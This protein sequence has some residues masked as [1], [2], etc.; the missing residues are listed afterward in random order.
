MIPA[1][2]SPA[3]GCLPETLAQD[4]TALRAHLQGRLLPAPLSPEADLE[5]FGCHEIAG[6]PAEPEFFATASPAAVLL[7]LVPR[8]TGFGVLLTERAAHLRRHAGQVAF[9]GGR[10]E[11]GESAQQAAL[12][13][14]HEEIGLNP[15]FVA[16]LGFMPPYFSGTGYRVQPVVALVDAKAPFTAD[17][18]EVARIFEVPLRVVLDLANY[19]HSTIFWR[20]R[21]RKY[22]FL[23]HEGAYIWGVTAGILH[24]FATTCCTLTELP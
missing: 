4:E 3:Q 8:K 12:R 23:D 13:E 11:P 24:R 22:Y 15:A 5:R 7:A 9:P 14:A 21:E 10:V 1:P 2:A 16:P 20:E 19:R 17:P 18:S 6:I